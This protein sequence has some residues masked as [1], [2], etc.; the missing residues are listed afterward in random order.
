MR[1]FN[2]WVRIWQTSWWIEGSFWTIKRL[3]TPFLS[4]KFA[5][6]EL[7][8]KW[9]L[10]QGG[11]LD[12]TRH[13]NIQIDCFSYQSSQIKPPPQQQTQPFIGQSIQNIFHVT[14][15]SM[16]CQHFLVNRVKLYCNLISFHLFCVCCVCILSAK[17]FLNLCNHKVK[18]KTAAIPI[19]IKVNNTTTDNLFNNVLL[20]R[21]TIRCTSQDKTMRQ[22]T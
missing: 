11:Q 10:K 1:D 20:L 22:I 14:V 4:H 2:E 16:F 13:N 21:S 3:K 5:F 12:S 15:F 6:Y 18:L 7:N 8:F 9:A 17:I 19:I